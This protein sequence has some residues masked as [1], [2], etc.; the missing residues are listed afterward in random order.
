LPPIILFVPEIKLNP[1]AK[2]WRPRKQE[3]HPRFLK[4]GLC[5]DGVQSGIK[6]GG[7]IAGKSVG[8]DD[9]F[10]Y[11]LQRVFQIEAGLQQRLDVE[12]MKLFRIVFGP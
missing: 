6:L 9:A 5:L 7:R 3:P 11:H 10:D 2:E 1:A 4:V 8:A 12:L